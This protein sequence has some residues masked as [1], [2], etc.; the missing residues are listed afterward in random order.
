MGLQ[1]TGEGCPFQVTWRP[2]SRGLQETEALCWAWG[3]NPVKGK[4]SA[5]R[6]GWALPQAWEEQGLLW[7][8]HRS[9]GRRW[10]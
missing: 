6:G 8:S 4:N 10:L 9:P 2:L 5:R 1:P 3:G 7:V